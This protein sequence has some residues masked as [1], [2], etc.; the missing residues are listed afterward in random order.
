M[1]TALLQAFPKGSY[2]GLDQ[3]FG[4]EQ[5]EKMSK[6]ILSSLCNSFVLLNRHYFWEHSS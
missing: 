5:E 2:G 1:L 4:L 3:L 6:I